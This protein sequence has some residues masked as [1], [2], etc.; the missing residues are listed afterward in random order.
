MQE[1]HK[2]KEEEQR[3]RAEQAALGTPAEVPPA[4]PPPPE[5]RSLDELLSFIEAGGGPDASSAGEPPGARGTPARKKKPKAARKDPAAA[6]A[7]EQV[8]M[9]SP[10][11]PIGV[12]AL[13]AAAGHLPPTLK[14][15][16][17][18]ATAASSGGN[19]LIVS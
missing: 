16:F 12:L 9:L 15:G 5:T 2:R 17:V 11:C 4:I 18:L 19:I 8:P 10:S 7:H 3:L 14:L 1:L 13:R 6:A